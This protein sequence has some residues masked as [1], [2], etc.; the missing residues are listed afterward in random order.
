MRRETHLLGRGLLR[1]AFPAIRGLM[2]NRPLL[3]QTGFCQTGCLSNRAQSANTP[4]LRGIVVR[5]GQ[6]HEASEPMKRGRD[7]VPVLV[8]GGLLL[9]FAVIY[10]AFPAFNGMMRHN[11]CVASGRMN[12]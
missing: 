1:S 2:P 7:I 4:I 8:L 6:V 11:D 3:C 10:L 5:E 9:L 12:C